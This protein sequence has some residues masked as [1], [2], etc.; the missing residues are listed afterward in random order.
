MSYF[1]F[2]RHRSKQMHKQRIKHTPPLDMAAQ[3]ERLVVF[4]DIH[5]HC[6]LP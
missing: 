6:S 3:A 5:F 2:E 4:K 1:N